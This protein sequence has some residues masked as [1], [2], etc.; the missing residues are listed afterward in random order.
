MYTVIKIKKEYSTHLE[1]IVKY[2]NILN[3]LNSLSLSEND[4][5]LLAF[6]TFGSLK[7]KKKQFAEVFGCST[8]SFENGITKLV[9][10]GFLLRKDKEIII[11]PQLHIE[12]DSLALYIQIDDKG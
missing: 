12:F 7:G 9:K 4:I 1:C 10:K 11:H 2:F 8:S 3:V 5:H 6:A